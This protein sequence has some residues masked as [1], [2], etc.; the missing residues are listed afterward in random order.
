[1]AVLWSGC[2]GAESE[3]PGS[4]LPTQEEVI[5]LPEGE[6]PENEWTATL[7][8]PPEGTVERAWIAQGNYCAVSMNFTA[9][10]SQDYLERLKEAGFVPVVE[11][12]PQPLQ[13]QEDVISH[14]LLLQGEQVALSIS[15][16]TGGEESFGMSISRER[17]Q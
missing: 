3:E 7:P 9:Q 11:D 16:L 4:S 6:W 1:M 14:N 12:N 15:Y 10:Q 2:Q 8:D 5:W 17:A 13:G